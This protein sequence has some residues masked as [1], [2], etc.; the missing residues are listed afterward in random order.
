MENE[1]EHFLKLWV[2]KL[3]EN[4]KSLTTFD[5]SGNNIDD[6]GAKEIA[7][8]FKLNKYLTNLDL[9]WNN[10]GVKGAQQ[11]ADALK[12]NKSLTKI[13]LYNNNIDDLSPIKNLLQ[14]N[15]FY[16]EVLHLISKKKFSAK[17]LEL[18]KMAFEIKPFDRE[19]A[20]FARLSRFELSKICVSHEKEVSI[21]ITLEGKQKMKNKE[22]NK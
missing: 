22:K 14:A 17:I 3:K 21:K 11:I 8:S 4:S 15:V 16:S 13:D 2:K 19:I 18:L 6:E 9:S 7:D 12:M 20:L 1:H 10:I 5:L